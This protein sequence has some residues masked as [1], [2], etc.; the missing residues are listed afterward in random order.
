MRTEQTLPLVVAQTGA[1]S[2]LSTNRVLRNTYVLLSATLFFSAG[3]FGA[4][5]MMASI[6]VWLG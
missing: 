1:P 4:A 2:A 6:A 3:A 5:G